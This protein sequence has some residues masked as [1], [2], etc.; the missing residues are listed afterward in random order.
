MAVLLDLGTT[1][2]VIKEASIGA[3]GTFTNADAIGF[4]AGSGLTPAVESITREILNGSFVSCPSISGTESS[5]GD[6]TS[7]VG[8]QAVTGTEKGKLKAHLLYEAGLGSYV[9]AGAD[10]TTPFKVGIMPDPVSTPG[11]ADLYKLSKPDDAPISLS[12]IEFLGGT[13]TALQSK[14]VVVD[15]IA[16]TLTSGQIANAS[17]GCS[18]TG[19]STPTGLTAIDNLGCGAN[20]LVVKSAVC[21]LNGATINAQDITINITNQVVDRSAVTGT[22]IT[23]KVV[24]G[25]EVT[26][27]YTL[28]LEDLSLYTSLKNNTVAEFFVELANGTESMKIYL[29]RISYTAIDKG[30]DSNVLTLSVSAMATEDPTLKEALLIATKK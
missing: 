8:I 28:D 30:N 14:G 23:N 27:S 20:P 7:E 12:V 6:L 17:F 22:G 26:L 13:A 1:I 16:I 21:K 29:P 10:L 15:S 3:G 9:E 11:G 25:K 18:A 19:F 4:N 24:T 2:G 5:S